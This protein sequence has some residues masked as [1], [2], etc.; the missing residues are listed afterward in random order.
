MTEKRSRRK[1]TK[2]FKL[3]A[4]QLARGEDKAKI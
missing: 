1:Y 2:E 3:E 4:I